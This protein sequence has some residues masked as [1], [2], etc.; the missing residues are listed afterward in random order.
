MGTGYDGDNPFQQFVWFGAAIDVYVE[1]QHIRVASHIKPYAS[2]AMCVRQTHIDVTRGLTLSVNVSGTR[3]S[4]SAE[5]IYGI[6]EHSVWHAAV[7]RG[8]SPVVRW[9]QRSHGL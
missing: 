2:E 7:E 5:T 3:E 6:R 8:T 1:P 9:S 4:H